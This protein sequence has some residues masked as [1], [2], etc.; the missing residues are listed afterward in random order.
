MTAADQ[1]IEPPWWTPRK[2]AGPR[3]ALNREV[4][5]TAARKILRAEGIDGLS[6]RRLATELGTGPASL[7]AHVA[8]KEELLDL[9]FDQVTGE[10]PLPE[11]DPT[12]W[13]EQLTTLWTTA[14]AI[15][16][17]NGDIARVALGRVPLGPNAL[18][19]TELT[20]AL[21]CS[22]GIPPQA[23]A[24]AL[25]AMALYV[26]SSALESAINA[27]MER[28]GTP[29]EEYYARVGDYMR[30]L[31]RARYPAM[32]EIVEELSNGDRQERFAFGLELLI[33][34]LET[35]IEK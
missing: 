15:L 18:N 5:L 16:I 12:R 29:P 33:R 7:Y 35:H 11:P 34:G 21:L 28:E 14:H 1:P 2:N 6:M 19:V 24:W 9:L 22:A 26:A 17:E 10:V 27:A 23:V 3:R 13:R 30:G 32:A 20:S 31:P 8:N 4:I 25:D